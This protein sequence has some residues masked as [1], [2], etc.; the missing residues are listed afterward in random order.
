MREIRI[1]RALVASLRVARTLYHGTT[2]DNEQSI[3]DHGL[4]GGVGSF[5][6][7]AYDEY[8]DAGIEIPDLV[9]AADKKGLERSLTAMVHHIGKKLGKNFHSVTDNDIMNHGLLVVIHDEENEV[10]QRSEYDENYRGQY[11][12]QVEPGDY[13]SEELWA[14]KFV[15]GRQLLRLLERY[16]KWPRSWGPQDPARIK[17]M[18]GWLTTL[19]L[20]VKRDKSRQEIMDYIQ[21]LSDTKVE[22]TYSFYKARGY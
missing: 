19:F 15:K 17:K 1:A 20:R 6:Q 8:I 4:V 11:P 21:G 10:E 2:I 13:F 9:F 22:Q 18:R 14:D 16:G 5:V 3:R 12:P 7:D